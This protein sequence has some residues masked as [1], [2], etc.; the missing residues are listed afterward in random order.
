MIPSLENMEVFFDGF[1]KY[2]SKNSQFQ[3]M[4]KRIDF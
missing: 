3:P 2:K 1:S 4:Q